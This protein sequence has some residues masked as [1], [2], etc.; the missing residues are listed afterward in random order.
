MRMIYGLA[1]GGALVLAAGAAQASQL[2][3]FGTNSVPASDVSSTLLPGP[4]GELE[5][6][7]PDGYYVVGG[8]E[9][10]AVVAYPGHA[11]TVRTGRAAAGGEPVE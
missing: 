3:V 8:P 9:V 5:A 6:F 4:N 1:L 2:S 10:G 7:N 11:A